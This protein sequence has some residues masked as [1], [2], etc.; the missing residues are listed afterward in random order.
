MG[1]KIEC[2]QYGGF[3]CTIQANQAVKASK[4]QAKTNQRF[5]VVDFETGQH[6][7]L[8]V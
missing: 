3:S 5:K 4:R 7:R 1:G 2:L 6:P 8:L